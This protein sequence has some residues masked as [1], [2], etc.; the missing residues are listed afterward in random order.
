[1]IGSGCGCKEVVGHRA[2]KCVLMLLSM[3]RSEVLETMFMSGMVEG[4]TG[5]MKVRECS[6]EAFLAFVE[7]MY[8]GLGG[9]L[10]EGADGRELYTLAEVYGVSELKEY[11][12]DAIDEGCIAAAA[13][14]GRASGCGDEVAE[15]CVK[16]AWD[17]LGRVSEDSLKGV[18]V[19][20][21]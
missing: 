5:E 19:D 21:A 12:L 17:C 9:K 1:M 7:Y 20:V 14:Y 10:M 4:N 11:L 15:R 8:V 2:V 18:P 13:V 6:R 3:C 16:A